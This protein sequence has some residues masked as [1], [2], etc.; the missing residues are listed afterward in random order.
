[1]QEKLLQTIL[2]ASAKWFNWEAVLKG[3]LQILL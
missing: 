2:P 1:M 3:K